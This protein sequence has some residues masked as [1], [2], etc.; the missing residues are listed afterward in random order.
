MRG[1]FDAAGK[2]RGNRRAVR[3]DMGDLALRKPQAENNH[4]RKGNK[5]SEREGIDQGIGHAAV[6]KCGFVKFGQ[7]IWHKTQITSFGWT[8]R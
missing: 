2:L 3:Q 6:T 5:K 1:Q 4:Q 7:I 8:W